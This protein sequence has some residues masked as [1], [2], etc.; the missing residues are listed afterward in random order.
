MKDS[1][2]KEDRDD[3]STSSLSSWLSDPKPTAR[4]FFRFFHA[5]TETQGSGPPSTSIPVYKQG[6]RLELEQPRHMPIWYAT[7][8]RQRLSLRYHSVGRL[9]IY[10]KPELDNHSST[11]SL[12]KWPQW[13]T[14]GPG[15]S[16]NKSGVLSDFVTWMTEAKRLKCLL[17]PPGA[18]PEI[19]AGSRT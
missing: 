8:S 9:F 4:S 12:P 13:T 15:C 16:H 1:E 17:H 10:L 11:D 19:L 2:G 18:F 5:G 3:P 7:P 6:L 14:A